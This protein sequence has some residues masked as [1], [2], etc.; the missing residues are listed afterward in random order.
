MKKL[1]VLLH[2]SVEDVFN[3]V[4]HFSRYTF[5]NLEVYSCSENRAMGVVSIFKYETNETV[6]TQIKYKPFIRYS[7]S[8]RY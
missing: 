2:A 7:F 1:G 4:L 5:E 8:V 6:R 3:P